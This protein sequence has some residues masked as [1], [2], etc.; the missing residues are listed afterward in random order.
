MDFP[1]RAPNQTAG[2]QSRNVTR[3]IIVTVLTRLISRRE[4]LMPTAKASRLVAIDRISNL[5]FRNGDTTLSSAAFLD[6]RIILIPSAQSSTKAIQWSKAASAFAKNAPTKWPPI[7]IKAWKMPKNKAIF[8]ASCHRSVFTESP[9]A[10][11]TA[12]A[13]IA[14]PSAVTSVVKNKLIAQRK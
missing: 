1:S 14:R 11:A 7:G 3:P 5:L 13:S 9:L 10:I 2:R 8:N 12:T 4:K 6:S